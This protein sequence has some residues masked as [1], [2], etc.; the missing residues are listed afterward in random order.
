M[1]CNVMPGND[2]H[3]ALFVPI[4]KQ[5]TVACPVSQAYQ[6]KIKRPLV[7]PDPPNQMVLGVRGIR[8]KPLPPPLLSTTILEWPTL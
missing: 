5:A 6:H 7:L 8:T 2:D 4:E 1:T 3:S